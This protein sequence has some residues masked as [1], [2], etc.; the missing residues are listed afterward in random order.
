VWRIASAWLLVVVGGTSWL[1][2]VPAQAAGRSGFPGERR[3]RGI[4]ARTAELESGTVSREATGAALGY[5][6]ER[7]ELRDEDTDPRA[8]SSWL[9]RRAAA[10]TANPVVRDHARLALAR[11]ALEGGD[12]GAAVQHLA[13]ASVLTAFWV[14]GPFE[15]TGGAGFGVSLG[16][17]QDGSLDQRWDGLSR[18]VRWRRVD[19]VGPSGRLALHDHLWPADEVLGFAQVFIHSARAQAAALRVGASDQVMVSLNG[20]TVLVA[21]QVHRVAPDQH[22][23]GVNLREGWNSL[24][25]K[26]GQVRGGWTLVARVTAPD[27]S[28][29]T[30]WS[31]SVDPD[32][33]KEAQV[34]DPPVVKEVPSWD[35]VEGARAAVAASGTGAARALA[36]EELARLRR[37]LHLDDERV[38]PAGRVLLLEEALRETPTDPF[39]L[40]QLAQEVEPRDVNRAR[41][42][43]QAAVALDPGFAPGWLVLGRMRLRQD[44]GAEGR[45]ALVRAVAADGKYAAAAA[46]LAEERSSSGA[47]PD[48]PLRDLEAFTRRRPA[49]AAWEALVQLEQGRGALR[50]AA[51]R[52]QR[53]RAM[54]PGHRAAR[55]L[56]VEVARRRGDVPAWLAEVE[57]ARALDPHGEGAALD[58]ATALV[59]AGRHGDARDLLD[60]FVTA[61][62]DAVEAGRRLGQ[63]RQ[64]AGDVAGAV[65]A[66]RACLEVKPQE[67]GLRRHVE[68]LTGEGAFEDRHQ[69][70]V[71]A[72]LA[73]PPPPGAAEAGGYVLGHRVAYRLF[74]NGLTSHVVD[75]AYRLL[76]RGK[77]PLL[78]ELGAAYTPSRETLEVVRAERST[79]SGQVF[80]ADVREQEAGQQVGVY[81]D[82][83]RVVV[84]FPALEAGDVV[85]FTYRVDSVGERNLFGDFFGLVEPA[86]EQLPKAHFDLVVEAPPGRALTFRSVRLPEVTV[87]Q[88]MDRTVY[89]VSAT[90][91]RPLVLEPHMPPYPEVGA[92]VAASSY[93]R[94][95]DLARWYASLVRDQLELDDELKGLAAR[96]VAGVVDDREKVRRIHRHVLSQTRYVGIELGIHGWKPYRVTQVHA[97]GYGDCKDKA[98]LLVALLREVGVDARLTLIRTSNQGPLVDLP[99]MW[100]FNHAIAYVPSLALFLDGTAEFASV[101]ELPAMDQE[102]MALAVD[103]AT[104]AMERL[105]PPLSPATANQNQ[106]DYVITVGE[107]GSVHLQGEERFSGERAPDVRARYQDGARARETMEAELASVYPGAQVGQVTLADLSDLDA[108]AWYRFSAVIPSFGTPDAEGVLLPITLYPHDLEREYA[109]VASRTHDVVL[110]FPGLT[111]NRMRFVLPPTLVAGPLPRETRLVTPHLDFT[112]VVTPTPDGY[113]VDETTV[114]KTRRVPQKAYDSFRSAVVEADRRMRVKVRLSRRRSS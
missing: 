96:L 54:R 41:E 61:H 101:D 56:A 109:P 18:A 4:E 103:V 28:P 111:R 48:Q 35:P 81:T 52:A 79:I 6:W 64:G 99:T 23:V 76:D 38:A 60:R 108:P 86:Q 5:L 42:M 75:I 80:S 98:S 85:R 78:R 25:F 20:R 106:S 105:S 58:L 57:A 62:P 43:V 88:A 22:V 2:T 66:Y 15:N 9:T 27:G 107:D 16:P 44:L 82:V 55:A 112:Q 32:V 13:A 34:R 40:V 11:L 110:G 33:A 45:R 10:T 47:D 113:L 89:R 67:A 104:G 74:D 17:E 83:R 29:L 46:A 95:E 91:L 19:H 59:A 68:A 50:R 72:L 92:Y 70:D 39:L 114:I 71:A 65:A 37:V 87:T 12:P 21:D 63:L 36:L 100:A 3:W 73:E 102:G 24:L 51:E 94:W 53:L 77:A 49:V 30:G 14:L 93:A 1:W 31:S 7:V 69:L 26:V 8:L 97:R 90:A 84:E